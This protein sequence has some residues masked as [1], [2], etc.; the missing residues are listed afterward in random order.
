M[1]NPLY[2][3]VRPALLQVP[4]SISSQAGLGGDNPLY[5]NNE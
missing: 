1:N 5:N 4:S 3:K 2:K